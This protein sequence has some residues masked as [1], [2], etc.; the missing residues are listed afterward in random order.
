MSFPSKLLRGRRP[1]V[2]RSL[3]TLSGG[4][5]APPAD[6]HTFSYAW[7]ASAVQRRRSR[8]NRSQIAAVFHFGIEIFLL[9]KRPRSTFPELCACARWLVFRRAIAGRSSRALRLTSSW[10][11]LQPGRCSGLSAPRPLASFGRFPSSVILGALRGANVRPFFTPSSP[12]CRS[13]TGW[14]LSWD[15][16]VAGPA[17]G[18]TGAA[19]QVLPLARRP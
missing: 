11:R 2:Q 17:V 12:I 8:P 15:V 18:L 10:P 16:S 19:F 5:D 7:I 6:V 9:S 14:L 13:Q 3:L 1:G 4:L